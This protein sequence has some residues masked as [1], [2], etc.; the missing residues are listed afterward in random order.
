MIKIK[1]EEAEWE[2]PTNFDCVMSDY[3]LCCGQRM[4]EKCWNDN[5]QIERATLKSNCPFCRT[6]KK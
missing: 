4:C 3:M 2:E 6:V 1:K 5:E